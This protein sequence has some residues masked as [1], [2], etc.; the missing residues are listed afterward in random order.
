MEIFKGVW[1]EIDYHANA[2]VILKMFK[3][4]FW[5]EKCNIWSIQ[6]KGYSWRIN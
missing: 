4:G 6:E 3:T 5:N 2:K 1:T